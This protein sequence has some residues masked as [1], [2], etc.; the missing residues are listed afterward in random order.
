MESE[1]KTVEYREAKTVNILENGTK[2]KQ[3]IKKEAQ[4]TC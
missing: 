4:K 3:V 2:L 1:L